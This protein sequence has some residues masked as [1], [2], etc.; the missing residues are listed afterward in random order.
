[1]SCSYS[2]VY[3]WHGFAAP[4]DMGG[5]VNSVKAGSAVPMK[6]S[7][8]G[9]QGT[10]VVAAGSPTVAFGSC[11]P[12]A[13]VDAIE[14]TASAG[15]SGLQYDPASDQYVYVWK[16]DKSWAGKCATFSLQLDDGTTHSALFTFR[17]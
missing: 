11:S 2:V 14:E 4:V 13:T 17:K 10:G 9:D 15:A 7:L 6:F 5:V 12:T 8:H 16:T 1:V 3:D